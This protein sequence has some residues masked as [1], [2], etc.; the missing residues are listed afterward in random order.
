MYAYMSIVHLCD[1]DDIHD[2]VCDHVTAEQLLMVSNLVNY[3]VNYW[4]EELGRS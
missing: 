2:I 4:S 3:G 1:Q